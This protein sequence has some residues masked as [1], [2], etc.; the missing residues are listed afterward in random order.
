[1]TLKIIDLCAGTGAFSLAFKECETVFANDIVKESKTIYDLNHK[2]KLT[3]GDLH[4]TKT[5]IIPKHDILTAG[6]SCQPFSVAGLQRGFEDDRSDVIWKIMDIIKYHEPKCVILENVKNILT[7]DSGK[8]FK[9]IIDNLKQHNYHVKYKLLNTSDYGIP[10]HRE[11]IYIICLKSKDIYDKLSLDFSP[12]PKKKLSEFLETSVPAKYFYTE[13]SAIYPCL[14]KDITKKDV[15]YQ[16]RRY[17]VRENKSGECPTLTANMGTGGH[18]VPIILS[19]T[20][21][22]KLTPRECFNLQGF[23]K[24]FILP[25]NVADS[26][27]YKL[28]GNAVSYP[29]VKAIA[30]RLI[31]LLNES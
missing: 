24:D 2:N 20:R 31:P 22:R 13:D 27:L 6:F 16:Y 14:L 26:H 3:L 29:I 11:R 15:I 25:N 18:N 1:M 9:I 19:E 7:H 23:P 28:A 8:T 30:D 10:Q 21:P 12:I 5:E 17:Y 4:L